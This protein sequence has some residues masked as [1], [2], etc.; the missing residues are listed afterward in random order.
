MILVSFCRILNGLSEEISLFWRYSSPLSQ[1]VHTLQDWTASSQSDLLIRG[2]SKTYWASNSVTIDSWI[3]LE[4]NLARNIG[5]ELSSNG[6]N[7]NRQQ[8]AKN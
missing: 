5:R 8:F 1:K 2:P 3:V 4:N 7:K 6:S